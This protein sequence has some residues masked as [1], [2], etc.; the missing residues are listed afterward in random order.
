MAGKSHKNVLEGIR[1]VLKEA[2]IEPAEFLAS[3]KNSTGRLK[4]MPLILTTPV[5]WGKLNKKSSY[6]NL[7]F[8]ACIINL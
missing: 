7:P 3:Y 2:G 1:D 6:F 5:F 4:Y 8:F